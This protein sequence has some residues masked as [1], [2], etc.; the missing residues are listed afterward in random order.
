IIVIATHDPVLALSADRR[1]VFE[2]GAVK[3][4]QSRTGNE[5]ALLARLSEIERELSRVRVLLRAGGTLI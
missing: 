3:L 4:V 1:V 2:H 5:E